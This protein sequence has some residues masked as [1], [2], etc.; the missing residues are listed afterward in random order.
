[1][2]KGFDMELKNIYKNLAKSVEFANLDGDFKK[3]IDNFLIQYSEGKRIVFQ[4]TDPEDPDFPE[5]Y[6]IGNL[7]WFKTV[8]SCIPV[9]N[10]I[11][12][13]S[14]QNYHDL[15]EGFYYPSLENIT[16]FLSKEE[17]SIGY[18]EV[19][20]NFFT[21]LT[22]YPIDEQLLILQLLIEGIKNQQIDTEKLDSLQTL[23][24]LTFYLAHTFLQE[25]MSA[26]LKDEVNKM[27]AN[28]QFNSVYEKIPTQYLSTNK[29]EVIEL[30]N[31]LCEYHL[32]KSTL[33]PDSLAEFTLPVWQVVP[34]EILVLLHLRT[35]KGLEIDM[36]EHPLIKPYIPFIKNEISISTKQQQLR[37]SIFNQFNYLPIIAL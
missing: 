29:A 32:D 36:I 2:V 25:A 10:F 28:Y 22:Y 27:L 19:A 20:M 1:M 14:V 15:I 3:V 12:A 7:L 35:Q 24:P 31:T 16:T 11:K 23:F 34:W 9:E 17:K 5:V 37:R 30:F 26:N 8:E 21:A 13:P 4:Y 33:D 6:T 18:N